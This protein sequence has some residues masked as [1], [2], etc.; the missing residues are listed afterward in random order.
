MSLQP[1]A[2]PP[3]PEVTARVARKAFR[4]GNLYLTIGDQLGQLFSDEDFADLYALQ[5]APGISPAQLILVL[6]FQ[7]LENLSDREAAEAVCGRIEWKY[8]LHLELEDPGFH[9]AVLSDFRARLVQHA[10]VPRILDRILDR[11]RALGLLKKRGQQ[12][13][14][15]TYV[16]SATRTLHRL[17]LA[18]ETVRLALEALAEVSP[19][20]LQGIA[21]P[22]WWERYTLAW[23]GTRGPK[24]EA[25][26]AAWITAVG[27]DGAYLLVMVQQ[28]EAPAGLL[29]L[30]AL[31]HLAQ[32]WDQQYEHGPTGWQ[33]RAE[34]QTPPAAELLATPHDPETRYSKKRDTS[35]TGYKV[36]FTETCEADQPHLVTHVEVTPATQP[37][38]ST[39]PTIHAAL[40]RRECLPGRHLVDAGYVSGPTLTESQEK[41]GVELWGPVATDSSW[42][43]K[44][45]GGF[46]AERFSIDWAQ[47]R[48][49]CP[50]GQWASTWSESQDEYGHPVVL[51]RF[52]AAQ[53][54][55][56]ASHSR[57]THS[58]R[59]RSLYVRP[60]F[61]V[62]A[63]ARQRQRTD[64]FWQ[65]Y[66]QRAGIEGTISEA[67]RA[68]G[69]RV[70]RYSGQAKTWLQET[71]LAAAINLER[72]ARWLMGE[73]PKTT[74]VSHFMAL[75]PEGGLAG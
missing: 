3:L 38:V 7:A 67:V 63:M 75:A 43:A 51:I 24:D 45:T 49:S 32:I 13:T 52:P 40:A 17:E 61:T 21:R 65:E 48:A 31:Q 19:T 25:E 66:A 68:H 4:N 36:H 22:V 46:T 20:W 54:Q 37:D 42:Q 2:F 70:S 16:L 14:D 39:L 62:L 56:C 69:A 12:R 50:E 41:Y 64:S 74:R 8:A 5:G 72:A 60:H 35:W 55:A 28:A 6:I 59:G 30:P 58:P 15:S 9:F 53:C 10:A 47:Q 11:M 34:D 33:W 23:R 29:E 71:L 26:R 27:D 18:H 73:R 1:T 44:E 57:C